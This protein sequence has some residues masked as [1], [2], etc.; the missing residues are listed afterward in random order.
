MK[1]RRLA[2][3]LLLA[4]TGFVGC[5]DD[6]DGTNNK[7]D[8][9]DASVD[10]IDDDA[11]EADAGDVGPDTDPADVEEDTDPADVI[12]DVEED[13]E[14]DVGQD[15][16]EDA[17]NICGDG[18]DDNDCDY[19]G[20]YDCEEAQIGTDPCNHDTDG[21]GLGDLQELDNGTDPNNPDSDGDGLTDGQEVELG[22][23]PTKTDTY[24]N[25]TPD[26]EEWIVTACEDPSGEPVN[27]YV[28]N[29]V[30][31]DP[32]S[33]NQVNV[34]NWK[35]ALPP[36][37]NNY[38][39][40]TVSG[41]SMNGSI[42]ANRKAAAVYDDPTNEVA[43][44]LLSYTPNSSQ[45]DPIEVLDSLR[46][47][48]N[49]QG[50]IVQGFNGGM[51][52]THDFNKAAIGRYL[53]DV[54]S[55]SYKELRDSMLFS[56]AP[57]GQSDVTGLPTT[58]GADYTKYRLF[59]SAIYRDK[60]NEDQVL[61]S[62]ALAPADKYEAREKVQFRMD[63]LT[64]TTNIA[65]SVD[66]DQVRCN[67]FEPKESTKADFYWVLDQSGS[68]SDDYNRVQAV[69]NQFYNELRNTGLDYR[70]GV[71]TMD[72]AYNGRLLTPGWHTDLNSFLAAVNAV[73]NWSGN[74]YA[75]YGLKVAEEGIK[76][77]KGI[78]GT[79]P[80]NERVRPDAQLITIW[81]SDEESQ[82]I[83][84]NDLSGATGQQMLQNW[85]TFFSQHTIGFSIVGDG[86]GCGTHDGRSYK[87]V[88]Q[89][90]R[91][92][93]ASLCATDISETIEDIIFAASGYAGYQLP[94]TPISSSLRVFINGDWV[95]RSRENG[96][97]Y[98][99]QSNSLAFFGSYRPEVNATP[100]DNISIT[101]ETF[102]DR[103]KN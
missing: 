9:G 3:I 55:Q 64:N 78:S 50:S 62:V 59:V 2:L 49:A 16:D 57:F 86:S 21:D 40:L 75:E 22:L 98:F 101:Y 91:G 65:E 38:A 90:T 100:P 77:M 33:P 31:V 74:G 69:A 20:I 27:Y 10:V 25:G 84:D 83:Q 48:I 45:A 4:T 97:D 6:P 29:N 88:A 23:D 70:L 63:D 103:S 54:S 30:Q 71:T 102:Q 87:E 41:L 17:T 47:A 5:S 14:D 52:D 34:G 95:P 26:N 92:S 32:N 66:G 79:P 43:G 7:L 46:T 24:G 11:D 35:L 15:V 13:V 72:E 58:S 1:I 93:F 99:A 39:E 76:F 18:I 61:I 60:S 36:A 80:A 68:M 12:E 82:S 81:I 56:M 67:I 51:F 89:A 42:P 94:D 85:I 19:D 53:L 28:S 8:K 37:F 73:I 96:F 44:F